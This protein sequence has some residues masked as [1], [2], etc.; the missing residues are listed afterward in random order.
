MMIFFRLLNSLFS[1]LFESK[2]RRVVG[3]CKVDKDVNAV[4]LCDEPYTTEDLSKIRGGVTY[5]TT[6]K[7]TLVFDFTNP[8]VSYALTFLLFPLRQSH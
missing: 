2:R 4:Q 7:E 5:L 8:Q 6:P 3:S 1:C